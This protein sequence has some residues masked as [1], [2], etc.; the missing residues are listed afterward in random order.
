MK[1]GSIM[2]IKGNLYEY[3]QYDERAK[4]HIAHEV[5]IDDEGRLTATYDAYAFSNEEIKDNST[6]FTKQQW[7][8]IVEHFIR[9]DNDDLT[10]DDVANATEDIVGR[11]FAYGIP[12]IEELPQYV[13]EYLNR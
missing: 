8:G 10:D 9:Q 5:L 13:A 7:Y 12:S 1:K 11:C 3:D 6:N 4:M 2:A